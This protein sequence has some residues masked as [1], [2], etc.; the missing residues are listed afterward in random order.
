MPFK[1]PEKA[2]EANRRY[3]DRNR[4]QIRARNLA[5]YHATKDERGEHNRALERKRYQKNSEQLIAKVRRQQA[6][7]YD[8]VATLKTA[9][10]SDCGIT[11]QP[12]VMDFDHRPGE[13]KARRGIVGLI[14]SGSVET[15]IAEIAKCDLVCANCHRI[16][17]CKTHHVTHRQA[18]GA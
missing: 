1:D 15:L 8:I 14:T 9:P 16:R 17:T 11:Y 13:R 5:Y 3:R 10:C 6:K 4:E 18:A 7:K 12:C 2:A